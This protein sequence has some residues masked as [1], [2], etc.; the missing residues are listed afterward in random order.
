[1][2]KQ[3]SAVEII[4]DE[5]QGETLTVAGWRDVPV[6]TE[7]LGEV[8]LSSMPAIAQ[9]LVTGPSGWGSKDLERRLYMVRRRIRKT[10][11]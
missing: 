9:V 11:C 1:L 4:N 2:Q 5:L 8:A 10:H 3:E 7:V 6:N